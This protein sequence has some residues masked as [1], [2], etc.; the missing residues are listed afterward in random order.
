M[1]PNTSAD[2]ASAVATADVLQNFASQHAGAVGQTTLMVSIA[3]NAVGKREQEKLDLQNCYAGTGSPSLEVHFL[4]NEKTQLVK[5]L[6]QFSPDAPK[7]SGCS[8]V[9]KKR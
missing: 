9:S 1:A 6:L 3:D 8:K 7:R 4:G 5:I 2:P